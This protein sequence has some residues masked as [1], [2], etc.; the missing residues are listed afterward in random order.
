MIKKIAALAV[1]LAAGTA[2]AAG[3]YDGI[4]F[5]PASNGYFSVHTNGNVM[6]AVGLSA[7]PANNIQFT[8]ALGVVR[9]NSIATWEVATGNVSGSN[10]ILLGTNLFG[11]CDVTYDIDFAPGVATAR[12]AGSIQSALGRQNGINCAALTAT[13]VLTL[14]RAF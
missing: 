4:Y 2:H 13:P 7:V 1:L 6:I 14:P 9:A 8:T 10:A 11:A 5:N 12:I 3:P